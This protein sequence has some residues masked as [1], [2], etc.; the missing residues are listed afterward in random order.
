MLKAI[1]QFQHSVVQNDCADVPI[2]VWTVFCTC[3]TPQAKKSEKADWQTK[4]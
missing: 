1:N 2:R 3:F 4:K